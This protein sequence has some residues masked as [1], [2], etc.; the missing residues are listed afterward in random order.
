MFEWTY[1][2]LNNF[3]PSIIHHNIPLNLDINPYQQK[4]K[5]MHPILDPSL[6]KELDKILNA[7]IVFPVRYTQWISNFSPVHKKS[8]EIRL[9]VDFRNFN[10]ESEK[11]NYLVPSMEMILQTVSDVEMFS[12]LDG[13]SGYNQVLVTNSNQLKTSFRRP[14]GTFSYRRIPFGMINVVDT[15][16]RAMDIAFQGLLQNFAVIYLNGIT[17][18]YEEMTRSYTSLETCF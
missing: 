13:F 5:K 12:L 16:Q 11:D 1:D 4:L 10:R 6:K 8:G 17:I 7:R 9:F 3:Y 18:F 2:D 15:F 14:W